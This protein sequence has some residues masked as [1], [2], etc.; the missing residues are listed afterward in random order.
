MAGNH[1]RNGGRSA[2]RKRKIEKYNTQSVIDKHKSRIKVR[3]L[4]KHPNDT[5]K[6]TNP[7]YQKKYKIKNIGDIH[8]T[9]FG[10]VKYLDFWIQTNMD[11]DANRK[12]RIV[13]LLEK[14]REIRKTMKMDNVMVGYTQQ[15]KH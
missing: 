10:C 8:P 7:Q 9:K 14:F 6:H 11:V 1:K 5:G 13:S 4:K 3:H 2:S 15:L 12:R